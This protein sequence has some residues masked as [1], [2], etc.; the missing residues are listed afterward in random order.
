MFMVVSKSVGQIGNLSY[1]AEIIQQ[2]PIS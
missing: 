2:N 1:K